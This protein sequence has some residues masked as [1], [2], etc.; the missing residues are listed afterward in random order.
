[1]LLENYLLKK[2]PIK[3]LRQ[4]TITPPKKRT[5]DNSVPKV[6]LASNPT[7]I[8]MTEIAPIAKKG[9]IL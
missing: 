9:Y 8:A 2:D 7:K 5:P 3:T 1:M 6:S 4:P